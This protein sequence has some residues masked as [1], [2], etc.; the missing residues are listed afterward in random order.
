MTL[1][2][3]LEHRLLWINLCNHRLLLVIS[4]EQVVPLCPAIEAKVYFPAIYAHHRHLSQPPTSDIFVS[5]EK[6]VSFSCNSI[7]EL[8][9]FPSRIPEAYFTHTHTQF[10]IPD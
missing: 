1:T 2:H 8:D 6:K 9:F 4:T 7:L 5:K 3:A 10:A